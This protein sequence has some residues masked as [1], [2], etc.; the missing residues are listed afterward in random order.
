MSADAGAG[1]ALERHGDGESMS[2]IVPAI[3][4]VKYRKASQCSSA[5]HHLL[6]NICANIVLDVADRGILH[7]E[8]QH[9]EIQHEAASTA[10]RGSLI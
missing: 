9:A 10:K 2:T 7:P 1:T 5:H 8:I 6:K 3:L 4:G